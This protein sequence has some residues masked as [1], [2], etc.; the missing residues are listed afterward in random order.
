MVR[1]SAGL[2]A[3]GSMV[4]VC[5]AQALGLGALEVRSHL[6]QRLDA[7]IPVSSGTPGELEGLVVELATNDEFERAGLER[8]EFLS[9][10]QFEVKDGGIYVRSKDLAREPFVTFLL[11]VQWN[12]GRL[13]REYTVLLDPPMQASPARA[14]AELS[15]EPPPQANV[16][17]PVVV[18]EEA[19]E[20]MPVE[21]TET[22][23]VE[24]PAVQPTL[25]AVASTVPAAATMAE[26]VDTVS[27]VPTEQPASPAPVDEGQIYGPV[28]GN[29]TLWS[30]AFKLR[31]DPSITMDQMQ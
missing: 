9:L 24:P 17:P 5:V 31:P 12:S 1:M 8:A 16:A 11:S 13:L 23:Q 2:L 29:E 22:S 10:L 4:W 7:F 20:L 30:V 15:P 28:Q 19:S 14:G 26:P 25:P 27:P 6:N 21:P 18:Q 3:V